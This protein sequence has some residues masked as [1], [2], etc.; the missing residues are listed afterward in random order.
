MKIGLQK[1]NLCENYF[2]FCLYNRFSIFYL[3]FVLKIYPYFNIRTPCF[4]KIPNVSQEEIR[5]MIINES[6]MMQLT[7]NQIL[8]LKKIAIFDWGNQWDFTAKVFVVL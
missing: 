5:R 6:F 3:L 2:V 4:L 7:V 1:Q 8:W